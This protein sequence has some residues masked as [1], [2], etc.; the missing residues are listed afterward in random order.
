MALASADPTLFIW[1]KNTTS[2]AF[3]NTLIIILIAIAI[4]FPLSLLIALYINE[5]AKEGKMKKVLVFFIDSLGATPSILFGM[6]GLIFFIQVCGMTSQ[7]VAGKSMIAGILTILIVI[8]PTFIRTI[9]QSL[10]SVPMELRENSYALGSG[11]WETIRK[12][13]LPIALQGIMT[14]VVLSIGRILAETAPLYLTSGLSSSS[15]ISLLTSGQ[16]LT[17]RIYAQ[18]YEAGVVKGTNI[19]YECAIVTMILVLIII[20]IVH[21]AIPAYYKHKRKKDE[22]MYAALKQLYEKKEKHLTEQQLKEKEN[23]KEIKYEKFKKPIIIPKVNYNY[24]FY[25]LNLSRRRIF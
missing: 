1:G 11:K 25:R 21:V 9:Q 23:I 16:T 3:V 14:S 6:V 18:I 7:V 10:A 12:I 13:V 5:F 15:S 8:L 2:M 24:N 4:G 22:M 17:T 20:L 19:M